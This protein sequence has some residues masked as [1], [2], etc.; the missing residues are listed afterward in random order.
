MFFT[1]EVKPNSQQR[2][3]LSISKKRA[4]RNLSVKLL[5]TTYTKAVHASDSVPENVLW[6]ITPI[7]NSL[8]QSYLFQEL[9]GRWRKDI[10]SWVIKK[11]P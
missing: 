11:I 2:G 3:L 9:Y 5:A 4:E 7:C 6:N 1:A 10:F 8:K